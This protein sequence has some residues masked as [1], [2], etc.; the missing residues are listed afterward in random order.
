MHCRWKPTTESEPCSHAVAICC[1]L[2]FWIRFPYDSDH[3]S[4]PFFF[5]VYSLDFFGSHRFC[6]GTSPLETCSATP[7]A[8]AG[9]ETPESCTCSHSNR[10]EFHHIW[11]R[12]ITFDLCVF[13]LNFHECMMWMHDMNAYECI[14]ECKILP[15]GTRQMRGI[16]AHP[17][18][19]VQE[20]NWLHQ[21]W[22]LVSKIQQHSPWT[23]TQKSLALCYA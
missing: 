2:K 11:S 19:K 1:N 9:D 20:P 8:T 15:P 17:H 10:A 18:A 21:P 16:R 7:R 6:S 22:S 23:L 12:F 3:D 14:L 5:V 4:D 13:A